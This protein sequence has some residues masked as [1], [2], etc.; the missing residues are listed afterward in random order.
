M[1]CS[2]TGNPGETSPHQLPEIIWTIQLAAA[3]LLAAASLLI[4]AALR[5]RSTFDKK[6]KN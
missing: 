1:I 5:K 2:P 4:L 6:R 3:A